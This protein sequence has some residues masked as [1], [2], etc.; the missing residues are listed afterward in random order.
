MVKNKPMM[1]NLLS[2][3]I[4]AALFA[5]SLVV[6]S[7]AQAQ[8]FF[9]K[10]KHTIKGKVVWHKHRHWAHKHHAQ[11]PPNEKNKFLVTWA[12]DQML[13]GNNCSPLDNVLEL[14]GG[15][16]AFD[17]NIPDSTVDCKGV[18]PDADFLAVID[19]NPRSST[20]GHVVNTAEMPAVYGEHLLSATDDFVDEALDL[21]LCLGSTSPTLSDATGTAPDPAGCNA[22]LGA[23]SANSIGLA[24][25]GLSAPATGDIL[26]G[27]P[28][29]GHGKGHTADALNLPPVVPA[30]SSVLNEPHHHAVFPF[31]AEDGSVNSYYGGLISSNVFGCD[32][33]DPMNI[34]PA[35][36]SM[37]E[38]VPVHGPG[39][40]VCGLSV[41]GADT[42]F[43]GLDDLEYNQSDKMY[44]ATMMGAGGDFNGA[45]SPTS[46]T[47]GSLPPVLTTPGGIMVFDPATGTNVMEVSAIPTAPVYGHGTFTGAGPKGTDMDVQGLYANADAGEMLGPKRY[48]PRVQLGFGGLDGNGHC[49]PGDLM[50]GAGVNA[51][52]L[53][54]PGVAPFNQIGPDTGARNEGPDTGLLT[55]PHGIGLRSNLQ[56]T[57]ADKNG[58]I[59]G[60][61]NGIL[62]T[63]DYADPVSL[64]LTG[65]GEG[66]AASKQDLGTTIRLWDLGNV[67]AGPYQVIEMP[68]GP[69]VE[70]NAIHEEPEGLMAMRMM[71]KG[72]GA[73][74][75]SMCGGIVYYAADI[76]VAKPEFKIVYDFG[77]CTGAS[78]FTITQDDNFMFMPI[79]GIQQAGDPIHDRDYVGE[80]DGRIAVLDLRNLTRKGVNHKCDAAPLEA[81]NNTGT[82]EH[83]SPID[84]APG[85]IGTAGLTY[86]NRKDINDGGDFWPNNGHWNCPDQVDMVNLSGSG[87]PGVAGSEHPDAETTRGGPHFTTHDRND[88]YIAT[89]N[90]FVDL[91]EFAIKDVDLLLTALGLGHGWDNGSDGS[92]PNAYPPGGPG[93]G[94]FPPGG[95]GGVH[96]LLGVD[97][98]AGN[99]LPGTGSIGDDTVCM[100]KW[101]RKQRNMRLDTRFNV[102]DPNSPTGCIDLDFGDTGA[103]WPANG[104]RNPGAG[105]ATPHAMS[106]VKVGSKRYFTNGQPQ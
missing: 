72:K 28:N 22:V 92:I 46:A 49:Q 54:V 102:G 29:F 96:A 47:G 19:A 63:S 105:N 37:L 58:N 32:I 62:M 14:R 95:L 35:L 75:A 25:T 74:V 80:H 82:G 65:S 64:A 88:R 18:L 1:R 5:G 104:T 48:A 60:K 31:V 53:C 34:K 101:N 77:A 73:F 42:T 41:S 83:V 38:N 68:D 9:D 97:G 12:G 23:G 33:T 56:G 89:S 69:R 2:A 20:Y 93:P 85:T 66:R 90:Y 50:T 81:W 36:N 27:V 94:E 91:R 7:G 98:G 70:D 40:Q 4:S 6:S 100:M 13:D 52:N 87:E 15:D 55:H 71:H 3:S 11:R 10:H 106:F 8:P 17:S 26:G 86:H 57:M 103:Q 61:S 24:G 84:G 59:L 43:S 99:I 21:A 76:T 39:A 79:S 78:V 45:Y 44:Y 16:P 51:M 30:P 67:A